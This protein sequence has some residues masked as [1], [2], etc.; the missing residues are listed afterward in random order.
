MYTHTWTFAPYACPSV[1]LNTFCF[2]PSLQLKLNVEELTRKLDSLQRQHIV[3]EEQLKEVY[4][5]KSKHLLSNLQELLRET[6][7]Y[8]VSISAEETRSEEP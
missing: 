1:C 3:V 8:N 4:S 5:N 6:A 7:I 2:V